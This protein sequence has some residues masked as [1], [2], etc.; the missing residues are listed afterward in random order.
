MVKCVLFSSVEPEVHYFPLDKEYIK[1]VLVVM[2][3]LYFQWQ[4]YAH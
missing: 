3:F 4:S 2:L 1:L